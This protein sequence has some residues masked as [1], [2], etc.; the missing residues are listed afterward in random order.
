MSHFRINPGE[1]SKVV[2]LPVITLKSAK[3]KKLKKDNQEKSQISFC[4][5][6]KNKR[7]YAKVLP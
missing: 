6:L 5:I 7:Y 3:N 1:E 2:S 4:K